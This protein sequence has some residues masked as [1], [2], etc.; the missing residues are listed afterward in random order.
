MAVSE[1]A[2]I[3]GDGVVRSGGKGIFRSE[4]IVRGE[5]AKTV[6]RKPDRNRTVRL[7]RTTEVAAAVQIKHDSISGIWR[8][9][10]FAGNPVQAGRS[11][12]HGG[13]NFVGKGPKNRARD[14]IIAATLETALDAPFDKPNRE[15]RLKTGHG[16]LRS[17]AC[18]ERDESIA[19]IVSAKS[20]FGK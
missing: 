2:A 19:D 13:R 12:T 16:A 10:P 8:L 1:E 3:G 17:R 20:R 11:N 6:L 14:T 7:R 9:D 5:N 15:M 4:A 18:A